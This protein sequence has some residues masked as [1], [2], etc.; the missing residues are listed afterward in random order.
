MNYLPGMAAYLQSLIYGFAG[1]RIRPERLEFHN[2]SLPDGWSYMEFKSFDYRGVEMN[3]IISYGM[4]EISV[5]NTEG[6]EPLKLRRNS[7][8]GF[9][10]EEDLTIGESLHTPSGGAVVFAKIHRPVGHL[11]YLPLMSDVET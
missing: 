5:L 10:V 2:P 9:D 8:Y 6:A 11:R 4:V 7:T 3:I 1:I